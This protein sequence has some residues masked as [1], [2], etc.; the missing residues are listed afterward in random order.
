MLQNVRAVVEAAGGTLHDVAFWRV[1]VVPGTALPDAL[2]AFRTAWG[3]GSEPPA[4][5]VVVVAGLA[6]PGLL[7]EIDAI[8]AISPAATRS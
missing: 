8:A 2:G 6:R 7:V 3:D 4:I 5:T 1:H